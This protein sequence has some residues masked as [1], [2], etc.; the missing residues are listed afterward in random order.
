MAATFY[1]LLIAL[2]LIS[3]I[4]ETH[5]RRCTTSFSRACVQ[6]RTTAKE[7]L[8]KPYKR[9]L[10]RKNILD[11]SADRDMESKDWFERK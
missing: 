4:A 5:T 10:S 2:C 7:I 9:V 3:S 8:K 1:V 6:K 11:F